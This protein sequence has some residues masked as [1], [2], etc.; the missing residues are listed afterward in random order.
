LKTP[1]S[2]FILAVKL[3]IL[4]VPA[5]KA[6]KELD[7]AYNTT[8]KIYKKLR[9]SIFKFV[10]KDDQLLSGGYFGGKRKG[11]R[12]R[13]AKNKIPVFGIIERNGKVKVEIVRDVSADMLLRETIKKVKKGSLIYYR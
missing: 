13:G 10:S 8:H 11:D 2:K 5:H 4:E 9:Q 7:L 12:G 1:F 3:F 6:H